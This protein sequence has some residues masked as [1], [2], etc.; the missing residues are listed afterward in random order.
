[1]ELQHRF[2]DC[3][4]KVESEVHG[5]AAGHDINT[6][7]REV[8]HEAVLKRGRVLH[9]GGVLAVNLPLERFPG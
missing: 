9:P 7:D 5:W 1:M 4:T 3:T 6:A 8:I 2:R